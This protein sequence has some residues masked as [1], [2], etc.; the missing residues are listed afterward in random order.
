M[1]PPS[2]NACHSQ[3]RRPLRNVSA[4]RGLAHDHAASRCGLRAARVR[5]CRAAAEA[6]TATAEE[7][8][9]E[10]AE[11]APPPGPIPYA[12]DTETF[13]DVFAFSGALPEVRTGVVKPVLPSGGPA[14]RM[15]MT[16]EVTRAG[17]G[18]HV[19]AS[20]FPS[21]ALRV[22]RRGT[23]HQG[24]ARGA[25]P[26]QRAANLE[27]LTL[28][29]V[30]SAACQRPCCNVG[31]CGGR[32]RGIRQPREHLAAGGRTPLRRNLLHA[33]HQRGIHH[34]KVCQ[35]RSHR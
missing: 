34:A 23:A 16:A 8:A 26:P 32:G 12:Q 14:A 6:E 28:W 15:A 17:I 24:A 27:H 10:T 9:A 5:P 2:R 13:Q 20:C 4:S 18:A 33:A 1:L 25:V 30:C 21:P 35:R 29:Y 22:S 7:D 11:D 19:V 31:L 3:A